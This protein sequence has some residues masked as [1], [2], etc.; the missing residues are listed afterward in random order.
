MLTAVD[1]RQLQARG[2]PQGERLAQAI[3]RCYAAILDVAK[4]RQEGQIEV[5]V[6]HLTPE[7][8]GELSCELEWGGFK[9]TPTYID[10]KKSKIVINWEATD[11]SQTDLREGSV[12][13][14][15]V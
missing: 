11:G 7:S 15:E 14:T 12:R 6:F 4:N 13:S 9:T 5:L 3:D 8:L 1:A 10:P 2:V